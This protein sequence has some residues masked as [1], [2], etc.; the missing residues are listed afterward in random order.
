MTAVE[1]QESKLAFQFLDALAERG[2][3][4]AQMFSG[5]GKL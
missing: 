5:P 3:I 2:L 4:D 1:E